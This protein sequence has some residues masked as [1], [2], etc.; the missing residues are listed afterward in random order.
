MSFKSEP[1]I[2]FRKNNKGKRAITFDSRDV[3]RGPRVRSPTR[4]G[5]T[6]AQFRKSKPP[7]YDGK[8]DPLAAERWIRK[9]EGIF[10]VKEVPNDKKV[11]FATQYLEGEAEY[12]W[13]GKR[14]TLGDEDATISWKYFKEAFNAQFFPK[15]FQAKMK[16]DFL[17]ISQGDSSVLD[18]AGRFNQMSRFAEHFMANEKEKAEHFFRGLRPEI[19]FTLASLLLTTYEDVLERAIKIEQEIMESGTQGIPQPKRP[20]FTNFQEI[21][22]RDSNKQR[23]TSRFE[24]GKSQTVQGACI[25]YGKYHS[26]QCYWKRGT[27]FLCGKMGHMRQNCPMQRD[28]PAG[29]RLCFVCG[30]PGH[31]ARFCSMRKDV[32][33]V[34]RPQ[35]NQPKQRAT[36]KVYA[37]TEEDAATSNTVVAET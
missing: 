18:Y 33:S 17:H 25:T 7:T 13:E 10:R 31:I 35:E 21:R 2:S 16:G 22:I 3:P 12:W 19:R 20:K 6:F 15:S 28:T 29:S 24:R 36:G 26:G 4:R 32:P 34:G 30:Q 1:L 37:M 11:D 14:S 9:I 23:S 5:Y 27:C 8:T